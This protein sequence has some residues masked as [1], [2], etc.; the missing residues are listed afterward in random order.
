MANV[1]D[2]SNLLGSIATAKD[3]A[4]AMAG[5]YGLN[6]VLEGRVI[7]PLPPYPQG[8]NVA[9]ENGGNYNEAETV[10]WQSAQ[11]SI[12]GTPMCFPLKIKPSSAPESDWW[13]LPVEPM[14]TLSGGNTIIRRNVAKAD[15]RGT[16]KER[17]S[18]NDYDIS[19]DGI[20]TKVNDWTYPSDDM[21]KLAEM[22]ETK[23]TIEVSC[24]LFEVFKISRIAV[25]KFDFPFTKGEENQAYH[26]S[27]YSDDKWSLLLDT[28]GNPVLKS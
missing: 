9:M 22:M 16:I 15:L 20:F 10:G 23:D 17:W 27:G 24:E 12:F 21:K 4:V 26:I 19:I 3:K 11:M 25:E 14:I 28:N 13:L 8:F 7:P 2:I 5:E 6:A 1:F 18:R